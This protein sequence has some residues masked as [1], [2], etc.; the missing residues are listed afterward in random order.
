MSKRGK[1]GRAPAGS[2]PGRRSTK[3][4]SAGP[5]PELVLPVLTAKDEK[6]RKAAHL[7]LFKRGRRPGARDWEL[8]Q[9]LGKDW[10]EHVKELNL[11]LGPLD[12]EVKRIE[13][14]SLAEGAEPPVRYLTLL[15]GT[16]KPAEAR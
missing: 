1:P 4:P 2:E 3:E 13:E 14:P 12:L 6:V 15:K 8:K 7:L 16:L 10:E 5:A 11:A 9:R